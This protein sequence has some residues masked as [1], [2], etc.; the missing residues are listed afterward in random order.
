[1]LLMAI[2]I[3]AAT[4]IFS[5]VNAV[6]LKPPPFGEPDRIVMIWET[7]PE[8][9]IDRNV[10]GGHEFPLWRERGRVFEDMA[11]LT[12]AGGRVTL[13][14]A[15]EPAVLTG[16]RVTAAFFGVM[17]VDPLL[18][19]TFRPEE[20]TP[21]QGQ[22]VVLSY[23]LWR[24]RFSA[25]PGILGRS[26]QLDDRTYVVVGVMGPTFSFPSNAS[27]PPPDFWAPIAEPIQNYRG[28]HYLHVIARLKEG[29]TVAHADVDM[30]RIAAEIVR[31]LPDLNRGHHARVV[32][33]HDDLAHD[34]RPS[35]LLLLSAV[36]CLLLVGCSNV[37]GLLVTNALGRRQEVAV[38]LA[39]GATRFDVGRQLLSESLLLSFV[40]AGLGVAATSWLTRLMPTFIPRQLVVLEAV[41]VDMTVLA[42]AA[43]AAVLTGLVFGL[44]PALQMGRVSLVQTLRQDQRSIAGGYPRLR[45]ALV[46]GQIALTL[47]LV[48]SAVL[49][50]RG[51]AMLAGVNPGFAT[52]GILV[53][54]VVLPA[55]GYPTAARQRQFAADVIDR[56][57]QLPG[58]ISAAVA[59]AA[60]LSAAY[61]TIAVDIENSPP[62]AGEERSARYRVVSADYFRTMGVTRIAGRVFEVTDARRAI[63]LIR[64][65]PQ[66]RLPAD[67]DAPQPPPVA[68]IGDA[69]SRRFWPD[70]NALGRRFRLLFSPWITVVG[71][72][73]DVRNQSLARSPV[74]EFYLHDLQEPQS[75]MS[76]LVRTAE[77]PAS[78]A[79]AVRQTIREI[80]PGLAVSSMYPI[81]ALA[82]RALVIPRFTSTIV[83]SFAV[84]ALL[85]MVAGLHAVIAFTTQQR[86][87]EIGV[88]RALGATTTQVVGM[89]LRQAIVLA[90]LGVAAGIVL[91]VP[92]TRLLETQLFE[93]GAFDPVSWSGVAL[94]V[95]LAVAAACW[96]PARRAARVDPA[97]VLRQS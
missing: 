58:V 33:L 29:A 16:I 28:R 49:L 79:P 17:G 23:R 21:G 27:S 25:N 87:R 42:F 62:A 53:T 51:L 66:Q 35:L 55:A 95:A 81:D 88:R 38:R 9:Q 19:R 69:M 22:V 8:R 56:A 7:R 77:S 41:H 84:V 46:V 10:V 52:T 31:E 61:S 5:V 57:S 54:D 20:D 3:G 30:A 93:V 96:W 68:V 76:L 50:A 4:S 36:A 89:V 83:G 59:S 63:P 32:S 75:G 26:I 64:W 48:S 70:G 6:L 47:T 44:A 34:A 74:P 24:D 94:L 90:G 85:L 92:L 14:G 60:P 18:G 97:V 13:A 78:L 37:A 65:F 91:S 39:L 15:G 1:V 73:A 11:A 80:D 82:D 67:F 86:L 71:V 45:G 72:V 2:A 43:T 12:Y 40:S